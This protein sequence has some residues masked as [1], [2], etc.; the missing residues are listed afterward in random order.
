MKEFCMA[1]TYFH[2]DANS[3]LTE[4]TPRIEWNDLWLVYVWCVWL[5]VV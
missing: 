2:T 4:N 5:L 1:F 3:L